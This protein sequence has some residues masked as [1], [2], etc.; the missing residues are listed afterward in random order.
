MN[1]HC[2]RE[3]YDSSEQ[4]QRKDLPLIR[5]CLGHPTSPIVTYRCTSLYQILMYGLKKTSNNSC[6]ESTENKCLSPDPVFSSAPDP[7]VHDNC[8]LWLRIYSCLGLLRQHNCCRY[9]EHALVGQPP[10]S[11]SRPLIS[12]PTQPERRQMVGCGFSQREIVVV[13]GY[14]YVFQF[15]PGSTQPF[16]YWRTLIYWQAP[17][18][19]T[20][21]CC[22]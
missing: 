2:R 8:L 20:R 6:R 12:T 16:Y 15:E 22:S 14:K 4:Q 3:A 5:H 18:G 1:H 17:K 7:P 21:V 10:H 19:G 11:S 13:P 9:F